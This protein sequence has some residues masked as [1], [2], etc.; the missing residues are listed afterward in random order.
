M[1]PKDKI[2]LSDSDFLR[3]IKYKDTTGNLA[4][5]TFVIVETSNNTVAVK[6]SVNSW[7]NKHRELEKE[8]IE[9]KKAHQYYLEL[10]NK[11]GVEL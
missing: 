10:Y 4:L 8:F 3:V 7:N 9:Y 1:L 2:Y 11:Y 6:Y 5:T